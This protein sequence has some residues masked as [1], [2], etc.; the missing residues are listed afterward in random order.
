[1]HEASN[2][3]ELLTQLGRAPS[4]R[5]VTYGDGT[6]GARVEAIADELAALV[7]SPAYCPDAV[8]RHLLE[9]TSACALARR[10]AGVLTECV[11]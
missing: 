1:M 8:N 5:L 9:P 10:L 2:A 6:A 7:A 11:S 4:I 3:S